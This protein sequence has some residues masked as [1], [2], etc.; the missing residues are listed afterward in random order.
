LCYDI[1]RGIVTP[2]HGRASRRWAQKALKGPQVTL[3]GTLEVRFLDGFLPRQGDQFEFV[4]A[5]TGL[6]GQFATVTFPDLAPG[7]EAGLQLA[8]MADCASRRSTMAS[9]VKANRISPRSRRPALA[10]SVS[11][12]RASRRFWR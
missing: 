12:A 3:G 7:F 8:T 1:S 4:Q 9:P 6:S 11:V 10:E 5:G 2:R